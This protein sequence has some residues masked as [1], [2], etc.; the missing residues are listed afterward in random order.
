M[1]RHHRRLLLDAGFLRAE[2][3][4]SVS[5]AGTP[6]KTRD[7]A[8]FLKAQLEGFAPTALAEGWIDQATV[9]A[10]SA[11]ID[12]WAVRPDALY[13]DMFCEALGWVSD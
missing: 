11:E 5:S 8:N 3:S 10:L 13:V 9:E 2:A 7:H 1:G 6:E 4:V 12:A